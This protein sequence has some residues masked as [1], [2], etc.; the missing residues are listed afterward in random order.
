MAR[1]RFVSDG[2]SSS[3]ARG[4][5]G[6]TAAS[7]PVPRRSSRI[8]SVRAP[9]GGPT[10]QRKSARVAERQASSQSSASVPHSRGGGTAASV[11]VPRKSARVAGTAGGNQAVS[12][13]EDDGA[14]S[15]SPPRPA[16]SPRSPSCQ[17]SPQ[18]QSVASPLPC[19][20]PKSL[21]PPRQSESS[22][23]RKQP[24]PSRPP[25][26]L[27]TP[28]SANSLVP[29]PVFSCVSLLFSLILSVFLILS[30]H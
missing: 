3:G 18:S 7:V 8:S 2:T 23:P 15:R 13:H 19:S 6:G 25:F 11:A 12:T 17:G 20:S 14:S 21:L 4:R 22:L 16:H 26:L 10:V 30:L 1:T 28:L 5:G 29:T 27:P 9:V 24:M